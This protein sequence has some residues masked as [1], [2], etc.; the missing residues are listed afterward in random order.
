MTNSKGEIEA[1]VFEFV[2]IV[3]DK[4]VVISYFV[5]IDLILHHIIGRESV[6][7]GVLESMC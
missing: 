2:Q 5:R 4:V 7:E 1:R 3:N 6:L